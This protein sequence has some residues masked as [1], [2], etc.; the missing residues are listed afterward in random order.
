VCSILGVGRTGEED[1]QQACLVPD[2]HSL[3]TQ[4]DVLCHFDDD[5]VGWKE[6]AR[7]VKIYKIM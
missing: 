4:L 6:T 1:A 2:R 5:T 3:F 7:S